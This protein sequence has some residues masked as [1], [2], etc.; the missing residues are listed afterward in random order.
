MNDSLHLVPKSNF[1]SYPTDD[2]LSSEGNKISK[3]GT[4]FPGS[5]KEASTSSM[6][7][8]R[9]FSISSLNYCK[10]KQNM[11]SEPGTISGCLVLSYFFLLIISIDVI[12]LHYDFISLKGKK[13]YY[14]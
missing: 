3:H 8:N 4:V 5:E 10:I 2:T 7:R 1:S 13:T 12:L 6:A 14:I 9:G 11:S